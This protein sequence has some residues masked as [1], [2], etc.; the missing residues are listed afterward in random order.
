MEFIVVNIAENV[1]INRLQ[2]IF[3]ILNSNAD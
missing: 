1:T 2:N 3:V